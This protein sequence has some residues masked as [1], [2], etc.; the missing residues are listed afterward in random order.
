MKR[1]I[2]SLL[3]RYEEEKSFHL[4]SNALQVLGFSPRYM[5]IFFD[6]F[7]KPLRDISFDEKYLRSVLKKNPG[8]ITIKR[9]LY[10]ETNRENNDWFRF[11]LSLDTFFRLNTCSLEWSNRNLDFLITSEQWG[12]F[13][14]LENI[15]SCYCYD[16]YDSFNQTNNNIDLF[17]L[18]YPNT[19]FKI[20]KDHLGD[21]AIDI[22]EHWGRFVDIHGL[23]FIAAPL[24]WY[25]E[26]IY[27]IIPKEK[28]LSYR[29]SSLINSSSFDLV[30]IK[31]FDLY[32]DPSKVENRDRQLEFWKFFDL[33]NRINRN[34]K[35]HPID[36][37][38]WLKARAALKKNKKT[39][40]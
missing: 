2:C 23:F 19:L 13:L 8:T 4:L 40:K 25:G 1:Y 6:E 12:S 34:E 16:Q 18:N 14:N 33:Q 11:K 30:H 20:S 3:Y 37:V 27:K 21:D 9:Q 10:D 38:G 7:Q 32:D 28:L 31:L 17:K 36:A 35:D 22:S 5:D 39:K 26:K 24:I 29:Y 15:I